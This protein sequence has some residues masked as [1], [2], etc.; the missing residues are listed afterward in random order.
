[1]GNSF[2]TKISHEWTIKGSWN[3]LYSFS[4]QRRHTVW[5]KKR[6]KQTEHPR[7]WS[8]R[9]GY[10][11]IPDRSSNKT[12]IFKKTLETLRW[13]TELIIPKISVSGTNWASELKIKTSL[14]NCWQIKIKKTEKKRPAHRIS[15]QYTI[16]NTKRTASQ[17]LSQ[18][19]KTL[20]V[21]RNYVISLHDSLKPHSWTMYVSGY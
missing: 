15:Q 12:G 3:V 19:K 18:S 17:T 8:A 9:H 7:D 16:T 14:E 11:L 5:D 21:N 6:E 20:G 13:L 10:F 2:Q 1:M 4:I